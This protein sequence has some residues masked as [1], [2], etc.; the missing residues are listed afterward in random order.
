MKPTPPTPELAVENGLINKEASGADIAVITIGRNAGEG[1]DRKL[2]NDFYLSDTEKTVIKNVADAFHAQHKKVVVVL[3][4][5][6]VIETASWRDNVDA[7]LLAWQPGLEAG[8][9]IADVLSGKVNPSGKLATTFPMD[10]QDVPSAKSFPGKEHPEQASGGT[11]GFMRG[12][13]ADVTYEEGVYVGYRYYNTF[14]VKPAYEFGYGLSYCNFTFGNL[15]L[16][17]STFNNSITATLTITN[18]GKM[19]GKEVVE[20]YISAPLKNIDKPAEELKAFAK[21]KLLKPGETQ[22]LSFIIK[23]ADLA[24]FYTDKEAWIADAGKYTLKA[25]AS[26]TD[27]RLSADFNLPTDIVVEKV[28]KVL[29]PQESINEMKPAA[30]NST[31]YIDELNGFVGMGM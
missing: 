12:V 23:A 14:N 28:N 22:T 16:S 6:G 25:G 3:N 10:Y 8:N 13:P 7:I 26:A 11:G 27:I 24:S 5:G 15:K 20:M 30:D 2:P 17:S 19:P 31:S 18:Q 9:A 21:T 1:R 4:I 29:V